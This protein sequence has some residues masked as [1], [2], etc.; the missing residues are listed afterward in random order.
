LAIIAVLLTY[1]AKETYG[2]ELSEEIL[3]DFKEIVE[4]N[5]LL[6]GCL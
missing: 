2:L 5:N 1:G 3:E 6:E 4:I